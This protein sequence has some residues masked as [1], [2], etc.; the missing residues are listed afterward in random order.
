MVYLLG[1]SRNLGS[2]H[3]LWGLIVDA[4]EQRAGRI[5]IDEATWSLNKVIN[6]IKFLYLMDI[7]DFAGFLEAVNFACVSK[8]FFG[9]F[10]R[11]HIK[12]SLWNEI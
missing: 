9:S 4:I 8:I 7:V 6:R 11:F 10:Y 5:S 1:I 3:R 12:S 2:K